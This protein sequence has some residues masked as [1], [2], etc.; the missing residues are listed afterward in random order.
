MFQ[1]DPGPRPLHDV[2]EEAVNAYQGQ[3]NSL[4]K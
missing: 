2:K 1:A 3:I 4:F